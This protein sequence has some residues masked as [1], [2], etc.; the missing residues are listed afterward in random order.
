MHSHQHIKEAGTDTLR[1]TY[2]RNPSEYYPLT[3]RA[4][5]LERPRLHYFSGRRLKPVFSPYLENHWHQTIQTM[6]EPEELT[7]SF[8]MHRTLGWEAAG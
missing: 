3:E 8:R 5:D 1:Q 2:G 4:Y 6:D 7:L